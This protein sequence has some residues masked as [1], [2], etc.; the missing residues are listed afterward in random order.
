MESTLQKID[1][2]IQDSLSFVRESISGL[3]NIL[4]YN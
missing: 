1:K 3:Q 2:E 4:G